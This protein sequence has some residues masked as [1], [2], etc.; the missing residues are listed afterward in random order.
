MNSNVKIKS[1]ADR[2]EFI[3]FPNWLNPPTNLREA[4]AVRTLWYVR[5]SVRHAVLARGDFSRLFDD[6]RAMAAWLKQASG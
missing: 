2:E 5:S 1:N 6:N 4:S 3:E